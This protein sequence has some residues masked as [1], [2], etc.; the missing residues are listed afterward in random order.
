M[1][2]NL[3]EQVWLANLNLVKFNLVNLTFG[4]ASGFDRKK[5]FMAIKPSGISYEELKP[6]DII[7]VDL[8]GKVVE[9]A[10]KP[11]SDTS[12]HLELYKTFKEING[13]SHTHS[14]YATIFAQAA[15]E[16]P[17]FGTTHAD[18]F[19][20][21]VPVT[22]YLTA[23]EVREDY[24]G[25]TGK[26]IVER[27]SGLNP[28]E[29]PAVLVAGHG[30]FSWGKTPLEAVEAS[31]VLEKVARMALGTLVINPEM[32]PLPE[33]ILHKHFERKHGPQAYYGQKQGE[34]NE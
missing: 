4:N 7:I 19:H 34:R 24:E 5:G 32:A 10:L 33:Y 2:S 3:K 22:R 31:L 23:E 9:G 20:G 6:S 29:M 11:S 8:E 1:E 26:V 21:A 30:P 17:C 13:V 15:L 12:T 27:F 16:I 25:S 28:L 14:E 18:F